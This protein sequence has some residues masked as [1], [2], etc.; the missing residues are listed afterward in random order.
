MDDGN[1]WNCCAT[2]MDSEKYEINGL[3]IWKYEWRTTGEHFLKKE[4]VYQTVNKIKV[5]EIG[6]ENQAAKFGAFEV[7]N[8]VWLIYTNY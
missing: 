1:N 8:N 3:N 4:T 7:S 5:Y 6:N 2:V